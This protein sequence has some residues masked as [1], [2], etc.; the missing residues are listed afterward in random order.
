[1]DPLGTSSL[2]VDGSRTG[3]A[4][5]LG[6]MESASNGSPGREIDDIEVG[7]LG[8]DGLER[9]LNFGCLNG[10]AVGEVDGRLVAVMGSIA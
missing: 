5:F 6:G 2:S 9:G 3:C 8:L 7:R 4:Y 1:M 10:S